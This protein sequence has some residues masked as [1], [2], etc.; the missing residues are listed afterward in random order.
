MLNN[1]LEN[2]F[3]H[4]GCVGSYYGFHSNECLVL[5]YV[6]LYE[7]VK[8]NDGLD[9]RHEDFLRTRVFIDATKDSTENLKIYLDYN[10]T[11]PIFA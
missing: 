2:K 4:A 10:P 1:Q 8:N 6:G 7:S 3:F 9:A 5:D 11:T